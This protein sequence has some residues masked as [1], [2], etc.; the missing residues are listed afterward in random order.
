MSAMSTDAAAS[1]PPEG[2]GEPLLVSVAVA[3]GVVLGF[4]FFDHWWSL[5]GLST[6]VRMWGDAPFDTYLLVLAMVPAVLLAV[7]LA[8]WGIDAR[9][10]FAGALAAVAAGLVD[11]GLQ[12]VLQRYLLDHHHTSRSTLLAYEWVVT[13][14]IPTLATI[15]WGLGRRRGSAWWLGVPVAPVLAGLHRQ[16]QLH[17]S[18][19]Q[20]WQLRHDQWWMHGLEFLAP[21]VAACIVCW[22]IDAATTRHRRRSRP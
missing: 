10:R 1:H 17:W 13:L 3:A 14:T 6:V 22:L 18:P 19:F 12:E 2:T 8:I 15:A 5:H 9:H 11:W 21:V 16:A 20:T 4:L 7:V